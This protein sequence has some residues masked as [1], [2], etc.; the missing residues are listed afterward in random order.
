MMIFVVIIAIIGIIIFVQ[1]QEKYAKSGNWIKF[2]I[3]LN[4]GIIGF[5]KFI[6]PGNAKYSDSTIWFYVSILINII[7][8]VLVFNKKLLAKKKII[9]GIII[10]YFLFMIGLPVYKFEDHTHIFDDLKTDIIG[11]SVLE[12]GATYEQ[13]IGY[14]E[15]YNCYGLR[16]YRQTK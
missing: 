13:I 2:M 3:I 1:E 5:I 16:I 10:L 7:M 12:D 15:Y 11:N 14:T 4:I 9:N 6:F 8:L